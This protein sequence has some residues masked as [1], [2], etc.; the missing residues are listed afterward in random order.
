MTVKVSKA[1]GK[2]VTALQTTTLPDLPEMPVVK[3]ELS[4]PTVSDDVATWWAALNANVLDDGLPPS[5]K[6][7]AAIDAMPP[8]DVT[9][10]VARLVSIL[11]PPPAREPTQILQFRRPDDADAYGNTNQPSLA[12]EGSLSGQ[13]VK[14][15]LRHEDIARAQQLWLEH[16]MMEARAQ[17]DDAMVGWV[18][19]NSGASLRPLTS[20]LRLAREIA[21]TEHLCPF[22]CL[23]LNGRGKDRY[24]AK[25]SFL[26][27]WLREH[28]S[29]NR[30]TTL[31]V[32]DSLHRV[33]KREHAHRT[34][35]FRQLRTTVVFT[36]MGA[37]ASAP[38]CETQ[39]WR[40]TFI[41]PVRPNHLH[42]EYAETNVPMT[43][44]DGDDVMSVVPHSV[45]DAV[46]SAIVAYYGY[47]HHSD[48][49]LPT[50][51][52]LPMIRAALDGEREIARH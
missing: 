37:D 19:F 40:S 12:A 33:L 13:P 42:G 46:R 15:R 52:Y 43:L 10:S 34:W 36:V 41:G 31:R 5:A 29:R 32:L 48:P 11:P 38:Y 47:D 28:H 22:R 25:W 44:I 50:P 3:A 26:V 27:D 35:T 18:N 2:C 16:Y 21:A 30:L 45:D 1:N 39:V 49:G 14:H 24:S 8:I 9:D 23:T 6:E 51:S 17:L 20:A 4:L 7:V